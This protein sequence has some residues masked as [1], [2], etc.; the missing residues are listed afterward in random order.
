MSLASPNVLSVSYSSL[1]WSF[2][3]PLPDCVPADLPRDKLRHAA[4]SVWRRFVSSGCIGAR[5]LQRDPVAFL[6]ALYASICADFGLAAKSAIHFELFGQSVAVLGTSKHEHL[7]D[8]LDTCEI[9]GCFCMTEV[10][11]GSNVA[12]LQTTARYDPSTQEF[13]I[14]TPSD[15]ARK[16][17]IGNSF[18]GSRSVTVVFARLM[19]PASDGQVVVDGVKC[20]D[21]GVHAF[22]APLFGTDG[23]PAQGV[24]H[25]DCGPKIGWH[26]VD[27]SCIHFRNVRVPRDNLL[28]KL[29]QVDASGA[30]HCAEK[31]PL[32]RFSKTLNALAFGRLIYCA[33]PVAAVQLGTLIATRY[34]YQR[35]QFGAPGQE[36]T[37]LKDYTTHQRALSSFVAESFVYAMH[38]F[39]LTQ[40]YVREGATADFHARI[41]GLKATIGEWSLHR[42]SRLR[43]MCGG[44]GYSQGARVGELRADMD[45]FCTAEG[46]TTVLRQSAA[47][48]LLKKAHKLQPTK[49][50]IGD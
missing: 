35:R 50:G 44:H 17:W 39:E 22:V 16:I 36:E 37:L 8:K 45:N 30:Y 7:L 27:N 32:L 12:A 47:R 13:V 4:A 48:L 42:L 9:I 23:R 1:L 29:A 5:Q 3:Y 49:H 46:D 33:G 20:N 43:I 6:A 24:T 31:S 2:T 28:D 14:N 21:M 41:S 19:L 18:T 11:H 15:S 10:A 40:L 25:L 38:T 34:A 26:A